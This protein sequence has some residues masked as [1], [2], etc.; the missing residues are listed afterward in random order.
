MIAIPPSPGGVAMAVIVSFIVSY[1]PFFSCK[2]QALK[3]G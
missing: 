3:V 2:K 1:R